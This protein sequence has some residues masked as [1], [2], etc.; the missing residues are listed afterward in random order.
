MLC[1]QDSGS[2]SFS[3]SYDVGKMNVNYAPGS[4]IQ[5]R[6]LVYLA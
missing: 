4:D 1:K 2:F 3:Q 5:V 6:W